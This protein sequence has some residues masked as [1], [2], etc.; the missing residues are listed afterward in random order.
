MIRTRVGYAGGTTNNPAYTNIGGHAETVQIEYDP[1]VI[2][3]DEL[4]DIF[5]KEHDPVFEPYSKQY[6]S[7]IFYHNE[8]QKKLA[9][10]TKQQEQQKKGK[11]I[12]TEVIPFSVFYLA[13]A[14]HQKSYLRL[15]PEILM[16]YERIYPDLNN[17][18]NSTAVTKVNGFL[19]GYGTIEDLEKQ[20]DS[21]GLSPPI[22]KLL[23]Q[24][25]KSGLPSE[26][27]VCP[28]P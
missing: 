17:L 28:I 5:W 26:G 21:F 27:S 22:A 8:E 4:L 13:E 9:V 19:G 1:T 3:Y 24:L 2:S 6:R 23:L 15:F 25:G 14:D 16:E 7:I 11:N 18:I 12:Y 20:L 10:E